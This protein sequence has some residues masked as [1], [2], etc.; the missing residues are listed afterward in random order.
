[1]ILSYAAPRK[2]RVFLRLFGLKLQIGNLRY[3]SLFMDLHEPQIKSS[4]KYVQMLHEDGR[5]ESQEYVCFNGE[6]M[7][8]GQ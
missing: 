7:L 1:M 4:T 5:E 2:M 6:Q 3:F 8:S